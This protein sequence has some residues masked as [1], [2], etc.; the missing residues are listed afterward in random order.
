MAV[1]GWR[2]Q[3]KYKC[4]HAEESCSKRHVRVLRG[5]EDH[6]RQRAIKHKISQEFEI[7]GIFYY[8][9]HYHSVSKSIH[10]NFEFCHPS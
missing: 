7:S 5:K 6:C 2:V 3:I 4:K 8:V 10:I 1:K 9:C